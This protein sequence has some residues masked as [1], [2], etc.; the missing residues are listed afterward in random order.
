MD[1]PMNANPQHAGADVE[2]RT[3]PAEEAALV[4]T[5]ERLAEP[6]FDAVLVAED[7]AGV[8]NLVGDAGGM[9]AHVDDERV[10]AL[11]QKS[12][13]Q[14]EAILAIGVRRAAD[15]LA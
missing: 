8:G 1:R 11:A 7:A 3:V 14:V 12:V 13:R 15:R 9:V 2:Q 5:D 4:A 10:A 6:A